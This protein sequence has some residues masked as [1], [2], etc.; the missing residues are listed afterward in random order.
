MSGVISYNASVTSVTNSVE[1]SVNV[2]SKNTNNRLSETSTIR[3]VIPLPPPNNITDLSATA[4]VGVINYS[5]TYTDLSSRDISG[6]EFTISPVVG[7]SGVIIVSRSSVTD[8]NK[9][10]T[11][12]LSGLTNGT[13]YTL[14]AKSININGD[15]SVLASNSVSARPLA[16][17]SAVTIAGTNEDDSEVSF[18]ITTLAAETDADFYK[19]TNITQQ[20]GAGAAVV[21]VPGVTSG[22]TSVVTGGGGTSARV[23]VVRVTGLTNRV[24]YTFSAQTTNK[25][26]TL[27]DVASVVL[28]PVIPAPVTYKSMSSG[29]QHTI[30]LD[31]SGRVW[32]WGINT[33]GQLGV[34]DT[35]FRSFA[36]QVGTI[37]NAVSVAC[38][39]SNSFAILSTGEVMAWGY[40]TAGRLGDGETLNRTS[41]VFVKT[42]ADVNLSN[43]VA[44]APS[45]THSVALTK[46]GR[47]WIWGSSGN[48]GTSI[49]LGVNVNATKATLVPDISNIVRVAAG[50]FFTILTQNDSKLLGCG[51]NN[52]GQLG[53]KNTTSL[54]AFQLI[55]SDISMVNVVDVVC[56]DTTTL[57]LA[58]DGRAYG[59]GDNTSD[60]GGN[61]IYKIIPGTSTSTSTST[62]TLIRQST[63]A[64]DN[65]TG[66]VNIHLSS[67]NTSY[68]LYN[69]RVRSMGENSAGQYG[70]G[71]TIN[72]GGYASSATE[73]IISSG[74]P[75][76]NAM[77]VSKT[78]PSNLIMLSDGTICGSGNQAGG[79]LGNG[80]TSNFI[81]SASS[82][83]QTASGVNLTGIRRVR[84]AFGAATFQAVQNTAYSVAE[85]CRLT[86]VL[87]Y[88]PGTAAAR[89]LA[90]VG[91]TGSWQYS[92]S[93]ST[94]TY[95]DIT[96]AGNE[97]ATLLQADPNVF[98]K[99]IT[100]GAT[101]SL[102]AWDRR[103]SGTSPAYGLVIV[104][105]NTTITEAADP[106]TFY[107]FSG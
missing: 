33:N 106:F 42:T 93:G 17:P 13:L 84:P 103:Y 18:S 88:M 19:I 89:G 6:F 79:L 58:A 90:V 102:K 8:T 72:S 48:I 41:P 23:E 36:T 53:N 31:I 3:K 95:T 76:V 49:G 35:T 40:G 64:G 50:A 52:R 20:S 71:N 85:I 15:M 7:G 46:N 92:T 43:V 73:A 11:G 34:S 91:F 65:L 96:L 2:R 12:V 44:I 104:G 30:A 82:I 68:V 38:G 16:K 54:N 5:F 69:G 78:S 39:S 1:Y 101:I 62:P 29:T 94:G 70:N 25:N 45:G 47:V 22:V 99:A 66:I 60:G 61:V 56:W 4:A 10:V 51:Y 32:A 67:A 26:G 97:Y 14:T 59:F 27:G 75:V 24:A 28:T 63:T 80:Q 77:Y 100:A 9:A 37:S 98:L 55:A 86:N 21:I 87:T 74:N 105:V 81:T 107:S 57:A 83:V